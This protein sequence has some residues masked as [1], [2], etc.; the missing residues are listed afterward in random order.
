MKNINFNI[1]ILCYIAFNSAA[2]CFWNGVLIMVLQRWIK[3]AWCGDSGFTYRIKSPF[4]KH[5]A[6]RITCD[7]QK[8]NKI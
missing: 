7:W 1:H 8:A 2:V 4:Q 6:A 3:V 5:I